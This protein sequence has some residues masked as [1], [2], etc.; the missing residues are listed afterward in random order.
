MTLGQTGWA[1]WVADGNGIWYD[2][3][4]EFRRRMAAA[5]LDPRSGETWLVNEFDRTTRLDTTE[6]LPAEIARNVTRP[7]PRQAMLDLVRGLYEGESGP[8]LPGAAEIGINFS[9]QNLP[10]VP[11]YKSEMKAWLEDSSFWAELRGACAGFFVRSTPT[12]ACTACPGR[13]S[14]SADVT[15]RPTRSICSRSPRRARDRRDGAFLPASDASSIAN[16]GYVAL[17]GDDFDFVTAHGNTEV[18]PTQM[19]YFVSE[20]VYAI[21]HYALRHPAGA[22]AG[23]SASRGIRST[24]SAFR[25]PS[26]RNRSPP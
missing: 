7:Y 16:A 19:M 15:S 14:T 6:R 21:R 25:Q 26:S 12:L 20:Q 5:G 13:P 11:G 4:V 1:K 10:D 22:P 23:G 17:G 18:A 24:A 8:P 9:H 2:A 3:G